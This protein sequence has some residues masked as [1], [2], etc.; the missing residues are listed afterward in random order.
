MVG[1][2]GR[3]ADVD[4]EILL[5]SS[6]AFCP[7]REGIAEDQCPASQSIGLPGWPL[8]IGATRKNCKISNFQLFRRTAL[9]FSSPSQERLQ[10]LRLGKRS[11][12]IFCEHRL[13]HTGLSHP[14]SVVTGN[15]IP[16]DNQNL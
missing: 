6:P 7:Y 3:D 1:E 8:L 16:R 4:T 11:L 15:V 9:D 10:T 5:D 13:V 14:Y 2:S 12:D